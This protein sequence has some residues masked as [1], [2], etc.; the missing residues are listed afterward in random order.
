MGLNEMKNID[1][2]DASCQQIFYLFIVNNSNLV[3]L[4][5]LHVK[6]ERWGSLVVQGGAK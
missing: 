1:I 2:T 3:S 4:L 5:Y 6:N